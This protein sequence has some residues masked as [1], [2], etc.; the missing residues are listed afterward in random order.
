MLPQR[1]TVTSQNFWR[2]AHVTKR[3]FDLGQWQRG[4]F[5]QT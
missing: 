1:S 4:A 2:L 3:A 5:M